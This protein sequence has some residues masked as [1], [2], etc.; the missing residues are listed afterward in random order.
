MADFN[1][2]IPTVLRNE[3]GYVDDPSDSGGETNFGISKRSYP[4]VDIK[5]LTVEE[6]SF[7]YRR[8][9]WKFDGINDQAVAT[10][11]LDSC[12]L[13]GRTA[14]R[15][16]QEIVVAPEDGEY[17]PHTEALINA[18]SPTAF[19]M[20]FRAD[21]AQHFRNIVATNPQDAKFLEGWLKRAAQ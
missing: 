13:A 3:G 1:L 14:I 5:N 2:A 15:I 19:L 6:A 21:L 7:F 16:A 20:Q 11:L 12:V 8:D 10:K 9:F 18:V 17:G 4:N